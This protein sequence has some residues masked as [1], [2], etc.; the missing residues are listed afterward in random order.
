[1]VMSMVDRKEAA[2]TAGVKTPGAGSLG[3]AWQ[4]HSHA[5]HIT[6]FQAS[7]HLSEATARKKRENC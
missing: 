5:K 2:T 3:V 1:M 6:F 4:G 7:T